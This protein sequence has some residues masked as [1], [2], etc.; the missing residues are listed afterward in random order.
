[1]RK[2]AL[3]NQQDDRLIVFVVQIIT[4][5]EPETGGIVPITCL[6]SDLGRLQYSW[7]GAD[8][9]LFADIYSSNLTAFLIAAQCQA[10]DSIT[11]AF[12][13]VNL[14]HHYW[15]RGFTFSKTVR[16]VIILQ[17]EKIAQS[18]PKNFGLPD[19]FLLE[20]KPLFPDT[21]RSCD[22][23]GARK[24]IMSHGPADG[25]FGSKDQKK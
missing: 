3:A 18:F 13:E 12:W 10:R 6:E 9:L 14:M 21:I 15:K 2:E 11:R 17:A 24:R 7:S 1:M 22:W 8:K 4:P 20:L 23:W 16:D 5:P 19:G 25:Q